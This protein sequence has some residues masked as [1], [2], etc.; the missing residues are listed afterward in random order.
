MTLEEF[1]KTFME[2]NGINEDVDEMVK[3]ISQEAKKV[4]KAGVA[5]LDEEQVEKIILG[6]KLEVPKSKPVE[7]KE[8]KVVK[9]EKP[10]PKPEPKPKKDDGQMDI[11]SLGVGL[12]D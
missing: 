7:H 5:V 6:A 3:H 11:F 10:K 8:I 2:A 9:L 4:A 1:T 12:Y